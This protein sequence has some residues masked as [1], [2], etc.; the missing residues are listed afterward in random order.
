MAALSFP[1]SDTTSLS[2][3]VAPG[4]YVFIC[5]LPARYS[6]GMCVAFKVQ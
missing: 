2:V 5:N 3:N 6:Q 4:A 1:T